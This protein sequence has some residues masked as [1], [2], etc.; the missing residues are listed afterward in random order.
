MSNLDPLPVPPST[1][2]TTPQR[3]IADLETQLAAVRAE[4][5]ARTDERDRAEAMFRQIEE[6]EEALLR[7]RQELRD[8]CDR[9]HEALTTIA[10]EKQDERLRGKA[11]GVALAMSYVD[12]WMRT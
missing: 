7:G 11:Q 1:A 3:R 2:G 9:A 4:L 5:D 12:D 10:E 8:R 6:Q